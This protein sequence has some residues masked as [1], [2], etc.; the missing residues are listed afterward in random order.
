MACRSLLQST[1]GHGPPW[2][3]A[4]DRDDIAVPP[5]AAAEVAHYAKIGG[6]GIAAVGALDATLE[7][8]DGLGGII[9]WLTE[10]GE[11]VGIFGSMLQPFR[12]LALTWPGIGR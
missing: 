5:S 10:A 6:A 8:A 3:E 4:P 2:R 9:G 7:P 1:T 11:V 12:E